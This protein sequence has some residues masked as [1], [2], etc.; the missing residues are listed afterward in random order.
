M[1][2]NQENILAIKN[3][4]LASEWHPTKNENLTPND[5]GI[6]SKKK[7]WWLGK[8]DHEWAATISSRN[9]GNGCPYCSGKYH[10]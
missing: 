4:Q 9:K 2:T 1:Q 10:H 5:V 8:C 7:V 6:G 3:P